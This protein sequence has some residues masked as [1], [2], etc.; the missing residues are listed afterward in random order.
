[1]F[2]IQGVN[3][4]DHEPRWMDVGVGSFPDGDNMQNVKLQIEGM[5]CGGCVRNVRAALEALPGV[6][7]KQVTV[8]ARRG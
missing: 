8:G 2:T 5:S 4:S 6:Q 7:V 3:E 1:M